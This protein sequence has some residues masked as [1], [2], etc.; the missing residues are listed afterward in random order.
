MQK[1]YILSVSL[2]FYAACLPTY[3]I[4]GVANGDPVLGIECLIGGPF[5]IFAG[6]I[7]VA[8]G[9]LAALMNVSYWLANPIYALAFYFTVLG[10]TRV[11]SM[12]ALISVGIMLS[13]LIAQRAPTGRDFTIEAVSI[14]IGYILWVT[15]GVILLIGNIKVI[16]PPHPAR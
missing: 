11:A 9:E 8:D 13:F 4:R 12:T 5:G 15:A 14:D 2:F 3:A 10:K 6:L 1:K 16:R 7:G